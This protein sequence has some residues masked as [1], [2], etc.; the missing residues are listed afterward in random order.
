MTAIGEAEPDADSDHADQ[1]DDP[2]AWKCCQTSTLLMMPEPV[3]LAV[4]GMDRLVLVVD[5]GT[6]PA[7]ETGGTV[8]TLRYFPD[9]AL[10]RPVRSSQP[11]ASK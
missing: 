8:S 10:Q 11:T 6:E 7:D 4:Y 3:S 2:A 5:A 1:S 9:P